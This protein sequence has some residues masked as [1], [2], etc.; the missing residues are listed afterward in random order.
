MIWT[1]V[2]FVVTLS[3]LLFIEQNHERLLNWR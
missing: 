1:M 2:G 3:A